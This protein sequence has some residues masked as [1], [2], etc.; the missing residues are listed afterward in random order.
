M[1]ANALE[2]IHGYDVVLDGVDNFPTK[3]SL[4]MHATLLENRL[5][6]EA[7]SGSKDASR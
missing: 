4:M 5:Y 6:M 3:F 2:L 7:F 1:A